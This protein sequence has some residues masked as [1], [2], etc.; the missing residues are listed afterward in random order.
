ME[1]IFWLVLDAGITAS[2]FLKHA[3]PQTK[4]PIKAEWGATSLT[5]CADSGFCGGRIA[6]RQLLGQRYDRP[7][8]IQTGR[9][10]VP[11]RRLHNKRG[12]CTAVALVL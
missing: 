2:G 1:N 12:L 5:G 9:D 4:P 3:C 7:G 11:V 10:T 8:D 6:V